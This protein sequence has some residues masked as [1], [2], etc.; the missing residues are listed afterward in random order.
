[1][2]SLVRLVPYFTPSWAG[3]NR[4]DSMVEREVPA[5]APVLRPPRPE[6][7]EAR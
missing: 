2:D 4:T 1:M 3:P 7:G 6:R 5:P